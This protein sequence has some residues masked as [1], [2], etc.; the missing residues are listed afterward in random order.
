MGC[1]IVEESE[2]WD[3]AKALHQL[4]CFDYTQARLNSLLMARNRY[5]SAQTLMTPLHMCKIERMR[6]KDSNV[7]TPS[8]GQSGRKAFVISH[9]TARH[10]SLAQ[11]MAGSVLADS[12]GPGR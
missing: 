11:E 2:N 5:S 10:P 4:V 9:A 12:A 3:H 6:G 1:L 8:D 7:P